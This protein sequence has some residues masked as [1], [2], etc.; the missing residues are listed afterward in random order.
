[1]RWLL[2]V[3]FVSAVL[4]HMIFPQHQEYIKNTVTPEKSTNSNRKG[5]VETSPKVKKSPPEINLINP[6]G[7]ATK[8]SG[9]LNLE[10]NAS[11]AQQGS[12]IYSGYASWSDTYNYIK[13]KQISENRFNRYM[14]YLLNG[15]PESSI[16]SNRKVFE[17]DLIT[18]A[19]ISGEYVV[20]HNHGF[21]AS[22]TP[23]IDLSDWYQPGTEVYGCY[24]N[25]IYVT[26]GA[27]YLYI[28]RDQNSSWIGKCACENYECKHIEPD[29]FF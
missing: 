24:I 15:F 14:E 9:P 11:I 17:S 10:A 22:D 21:L 12:S 16:L 29:Y 19:R 18:L 8:N 20:H 13:P 4:V 2:I 26:E 5:S 1:M 27:V 6:I 25:G 23:P 28:Q 7:I 3:G